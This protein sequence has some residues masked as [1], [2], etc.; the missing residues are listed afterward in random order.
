MSQK[1]NGSRQLLSTTSINN[2]FALIP[3]LKNISL[4]QIGSLDSGKT[5][6]QEEIFR[7]SFKQFIEIV[8]V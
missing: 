1:K 5:V 3:K 7:E 4:V 8:K 6:V 2:R